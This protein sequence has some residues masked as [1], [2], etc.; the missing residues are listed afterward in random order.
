MPFNRYRRTAYKPRYTKRP[1]AGR[2]S[3]KMKPR[4]SKRYNKASVSIIRNP[5]MSDTT[6]IK[7]TYSTNVA[8]SSTTGT[9]SY[10]TFAGNSLYDPDITG[11][12][13]QPLGYDQWTPLYNKYTVFGSKIEVNF[14]NVDAVTTN[15]PNAQ[16]VMVGLLPTPSAVSISNIAAAGDIMGMS[17]FPYGKYKV[18]NIV[19]AAPRLT[20]KGYLSTAKIDGV[21]KSKVNDDPNYTGLYNSNPTNMWRWNI[22][23]QA[24]DKASSVGG[25]LLVKITYYAKLLDRQIVPQS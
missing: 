11:V 6:Y 23:I 17:E 14:C 10:Y 19:D 9:P 12:G 7:F 16:N 5:Y 21:T 22:G 2:R 25:R 18:G 20:L 8:M 24:T 13:H 4:S 3:G 15:A 1:S